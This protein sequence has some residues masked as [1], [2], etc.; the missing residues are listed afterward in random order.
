[1]ISSWSSVV[2]LRDQ[3]YLHTGSER[4]LRYAKR[5]SGVHTVFSKHLR[6]QF[7]RT[8][9]HKVLLRECWRAV[10]QAHKL[11]DSPDVVQITGGKIQCCHLIDGDTPGGSDS[12]F[13]GDIQSKLPDPRL[14][15]LLRNMP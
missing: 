14:T 10:H 9:S 8:I 7:R 5:A 3:V 1:M 6:E 15:V 12:E 2:N 4:N 13:G 11:D